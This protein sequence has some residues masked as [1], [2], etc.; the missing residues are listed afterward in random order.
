M[1]VFIRSSSEA[2]IPNVM[3]MASTGDA[4]YGA[5]VDQ[6]VVVADMSVEEIATA[7]ANPALEVY[8]DI[9]FKPFDWW[10]REEEKARA[11]APAVPDPW[12]T[13][14]MADVMKHIKA[15]D[16]WNSVRGDE[17][18]IAVVDTGT[19]LTTRLFPRRSA[20]DISPSFATPT[21]DHVG[22]GSMCAA[23]ACASDEQGGRYKGVAP[24]ANLL[25][26]RSTFQASDLYAIFQHLLREKRRGNL[27]KGVVV[28]NSYG[29]Y[30]CSPPSFPKG[31][32]YIDLVRLCVQEGMVF[33]FAA[34]NNH[35]DGLCKHPAQDCAPNTIWSVN[36]IDEVITVG[37]VDWNESNQVAGGEHANSSRG[38][39]QWSSGDKPDVVAP[40]YG[41]VV[42]G[43]GFRHMEWWGTSGACPQVAGLAALLLA[44]DPSLSPAEIKKLIRD[45]ARP[46]SAAAT[47]VGKG[48]IDCGAAVAHA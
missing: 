29:L 34:G 48:I 8:D 1:K 4:A 39:G 18:T 41:E 30:T 45:T 10:E 38:P 28:S 36:S 2:Q 25:T 47:C 22:H 13:K 37:T 9:Q 20:L 23:I 14:T 46:L 19:D 32:P 21:Q 5:D 26:A 35:A 11:P 24:H 7:R 16:A 15:D 44:K 43:G 33:V 42:W 12:R 27:G 3:S 40:T 6:H 31:H 17:V